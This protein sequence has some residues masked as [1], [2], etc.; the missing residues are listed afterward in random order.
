VT[1]RDAARAVA[2]EV[3]LPGVPVSIRAEAD[4]PG[5]GVGTG[6]WRR[7][8]ERL[9]AAVGRSRVAVLT[10]PPGGVRDQLAGLL[11]VL[12][13]RAARYGRIAEVG[14]AL[15]PDDDATDC[16]GTAPGEV[17]T[18]RWTTTGSRAAG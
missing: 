18:G 6:H 9:S 4:A 3:G 7:H 1:N 13:L 8:V 5:A 14:H 10:A 16:D 17:P 11:H 12:E 2:A 15:W